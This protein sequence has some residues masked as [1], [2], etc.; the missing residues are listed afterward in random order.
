MRKYFY[1]IQSMTQGR[2]FLHLGYFILVSILIQ[3]FKLIPKFDKDLIDSASGAILGM[4]IAIIYIWPL[5]KKK[6]K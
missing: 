5:F 2:R 1:N 4:G 3:L 6:N